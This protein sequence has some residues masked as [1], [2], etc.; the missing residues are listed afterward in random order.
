MAQATD[1]TV[2]YLLYTL[3]QL[4]FGPGAMKTLYWPIL[5][6]ACSQSVWLSTRADYIL[7]AV[8]QFCTENGYKYITFADFDSNNLRQGNSTEFAFDHGLR[9]RSME[10]V[11]DFHLLHEMD[12]LVITYVS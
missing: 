3:R 9:I 7:D 5:V 8:F 4:Q 1:C 12:M 10:L 2:C 11:N 6:L